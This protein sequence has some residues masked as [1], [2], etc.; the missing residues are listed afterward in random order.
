MFSISTTRGCY[1]SYAGTE[2]LQDSVGLA[3]TTEVALRQ[4]SGTDAVYEYRAVASV[5][6]PN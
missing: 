5:V 4:H 6:L 3:N 1:R 2:L